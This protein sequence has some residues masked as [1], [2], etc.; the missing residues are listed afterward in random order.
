MQIVLYSN[1]NM[2]FINGRPDGLGNRIEELIH[3]EYFCEKHNETCN[4]Y[5]NNT[6]ACDTRKYNLFLRCKNIIIQSEKK[7]D[8]SICASKSDV[9]NE[10]NNIKTRD[11][12]VKVSKN[13]TFSFDHKTTNIEYCAVHI[14]STDK[15]LNRGPHEFTKDVLLQR[16][17]STAKYINDS[18]I[19]CI[20]ICCDD[21]R[22]ESL[23][24]SKLKP[25]VDILLN[26][27][28]CVHDPVYRDYVT[29]I[30]AKKIIM[31]PKYSSFSATASLLGDNVIC[32]FY[33]D[34][35]QFNNRYKS[36]VEKIEIV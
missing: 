16:I 30:N 12:L 3:I 31:C 32:S 36:N 29:L 26:P 11:I 20:V 34:T 22:Y 8:N 28:D 15:L 23:L 5:W 33:D 17:D 7:H 24:K 25:N 6:D 1:Y 13:I 21:K 18:N 19:G 2:F 4:Y 10:D 14:R 27:F 35:D 9:I